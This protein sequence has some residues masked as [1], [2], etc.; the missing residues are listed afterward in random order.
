MLGVICIPVMMFEKSEL[1]NVSRSA[2]SHEIRQ[3]FLTQN[4]G[5]RQLKNEKRTSE[6]RK[7]GRMFDKEKHS[8]M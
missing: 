2:Y 7:F 1:I 8:R 4:T 3:L 5:R 6:K